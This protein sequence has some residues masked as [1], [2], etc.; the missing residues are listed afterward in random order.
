M[1]RDTPAR[2][3]TWK[4]KLMDASK[5]I[6]ASSSWAPILSQF[7]WPYGRKG[8]AM[9]LF[10]REKSI[11]PEKDGSVYICCGVVCWDLGAETHPDR[12]NGA[13]LS[14]VGRGI[15]KVPTRVLLC[16]P[17]VRMQKCAKSIRD[18]KRRM[19]APSSQS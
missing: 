13:S 18:A 10:A 11:R 7:T 19:G 1:H 2:A 12:L 6:K 14:L 8:A 4:Q 3:R 17:D 15:Q 5:D 16:T 9:L